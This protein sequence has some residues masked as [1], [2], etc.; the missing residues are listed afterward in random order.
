M[1]RSVFLTKIDLAINLWLRFRD[2]CL[3]F[4]QDTIHFGHNIPKFG[5]PFSVIQVA[6]SN[7]SGFQSTKVRSLVL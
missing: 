4:I 5:T 3:G 7:Q 2:K 6:V 1:L